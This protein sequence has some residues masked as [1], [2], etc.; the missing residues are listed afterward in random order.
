M[1]EFVTP[2]SVR[3]FAGV[4]DQDRTCPNGECGCPGRGGVVTAVCAACFLG[5][6]E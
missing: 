5:G 4:A 3:R 6:D 1:C 2:H